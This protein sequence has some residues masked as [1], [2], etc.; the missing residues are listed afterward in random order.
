MLVLTCFGW[1]FLLFQIIFANHVLS[2][3][4]PMLH[5]DSLGGYS[6]AGY[7]LCLD[8]LGKFLSQFELFSS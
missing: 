6:G 8:F 3:L 4:G 7:F 5:T 2:S 1:W